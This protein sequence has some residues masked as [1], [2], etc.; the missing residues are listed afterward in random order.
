MEIFAEHDALEKLLAKLDE[1]LLSHAKALFV[2]C[3]IITVLPLMCLSSWE[4]SSITIIG[5]F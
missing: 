4:N 5:A 3:I 2:A 1:S